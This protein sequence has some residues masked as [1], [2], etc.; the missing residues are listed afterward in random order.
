MKA[1]GWQQHSIRGYFAVVVRKKPS[2]RAGKSSN[3]KSGL[4]IPANAFIACPLVP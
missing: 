3:S 4:N 1:T 2:S